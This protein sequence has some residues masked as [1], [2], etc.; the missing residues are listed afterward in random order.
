MDEA[1][2]ENKQKIKKYYFV[3]LRLVSDEENNILLLQ[4][5]D[6]E[7]LEIPCLK[8]EKSKILI[9]IQEVFMGSLN[10]ADD[11]VIIFRTKEAG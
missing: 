2:E 3:D 7:I 8:R 4:L 1:M 10:F 5:M 11:L 9:K 6:I